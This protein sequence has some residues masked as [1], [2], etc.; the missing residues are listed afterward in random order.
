LKGSYQQKYKSIHWSNSEKNFELWKKGKTGFPVVDAGMRQLN[1]TGYMHNRCRMVVANF[2]IKTLLIDW[3]KGEQYFAQKLTDY[4]PASNNGNWQSI[5]ATGV[6]M[7]P[8]FR[9]MNPWIQSV[10]FDKNAEYI[11]KW[12]PELKDVEPR[13][14]HKWYDSY[15]KPE[16]KNVYIKPIVDYDDQKKEMLKMYKNA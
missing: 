10:K 8:Y 1:E 11:K 4:D 9:D 5:S 14:I 15:S 3:R 6:D 7:K 16:Y 12:V 13:D 2:L